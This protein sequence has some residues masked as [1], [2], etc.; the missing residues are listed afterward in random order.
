[1]KCAAADETSFP[2]MKRE[3]VKQGGG[4]GAANFRKGV[5]V[6]EKKR[7]P[8]VAGLEELEGFQQ[9]QLGRAAF[10]PFFCSRRVSFRVNASLR[11]A[12]FTESAVDLG[13]R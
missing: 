10:F 5:A 13:D 11:T 2:A 8:P 3:F 9:G 4:Q 1:M 12:S 6:V 7:R